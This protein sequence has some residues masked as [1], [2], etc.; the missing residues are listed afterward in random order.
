MSIA[1][2]AARTSN[3]DFHR[4]GHLFGH[5][6]KERIKSVGVAAYPTTEARNTEG[7]LEHGSACI[8]KSRAK[9]SGE[10][11]WN[12]AKRG[13]F[14][15]DEQPSSVVSSTLTVQAAAAS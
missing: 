9:G 14:L 5:I 15:T 8:S 11:M 12:T 13:K 3:R 1:G 10:G 7:Y 2:V 6:E 4:M